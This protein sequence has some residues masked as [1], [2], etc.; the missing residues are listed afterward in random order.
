LIEFVEQKSLVL[1]SSRPLAAT[2]IALEIECFLITSTTSVTLPAQ[3]TMAAEILNG[4]TGRSTW[5]DSRVD[6][7]KK[8]DNWDM[9]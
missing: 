4:T 8:L 5:Q 1:S 7:R 9:I 3:T 2:K 6:V